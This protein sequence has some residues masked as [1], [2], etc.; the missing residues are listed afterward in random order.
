MYNLGSD[1]VIPDSLASE[2]FDFSQGQEGETRTGK[3][4]W[5]SHNIVALTNVS[6]CGAG[7]VCE[8]SE[9][10]TFTKEGR[11][12]DFYQ[13]EYEYGDCFFNDS[14]KSIYVSD[15][16]LIFRNKNL[17]MLDCNDPNTLAK[18]E[19][20]IEYLHVSEG[21]FQS[22]VLKKVNSQRKYY[23]S[24]SRFL[25]SEEL[26][27]YSKNELDVMRNEIF[28]SYG[29]KFKTEKWQNY[30]VNQTWYEPRFKD[31]NDRLSI[32]EKCNIQTI[33]EVSKTK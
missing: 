15:T 22:S 4:L 27:K 17:E 16:F 10:R 20:S 28:A 9:I 6:Y 31:V 14:K 5:N 11:P 26:N 23:I 3:I 32:I 29:Y 25:I 12:I 2:Y 30:F 21:V 8:S 24:S 1:I 18:N 13:Y 7:S 33:L 19:I